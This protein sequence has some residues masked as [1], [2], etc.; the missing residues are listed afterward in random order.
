M[1]LCVDFVAGQDDALY[2]LPNCQ[3]LVPGVLNVHWNLSDSV[4]DIALEGTIR[5]IGNQYLA[6]GFS[7]P[8]VP[9]ARM[10]GSTAL[11]GG[12]VGEQPFALNY[13]LGSKSTCDYATGNGVCPDF[14]GNST[15]PKTTSA[16]VIQAN[17]NGDAMAI[18]MTRPLGPTDGKENNEWPSDG[19]QVVI[20]AIGPVAEFSSVEEPEVLIHRVKT[21]GVSTATVKFDESKNDCTAIIDRQVIAAAE[22][23]MNT[24]V[25]DASPAPEP[26]PEIDPAPA[27][28]P[29]PPPPTEASSGPMASLGTSI[30]VML[31]LISLM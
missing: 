21:P 17:R 4:L 29:S 27:Q 5:D 3:E 30:I 11:I 14:A 25:P 31:S 8:G 9:S 6:F 24:V 10:T 1:R 18:H 13:E 23:P 2:G 20:Y 19:S 28:L 15:A 16:K 7:Q 26:L 22:P 12:F